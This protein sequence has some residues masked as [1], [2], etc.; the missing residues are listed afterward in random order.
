MDV[1]HGV[2]EHMPGASSAE[3]GRDVDAVGSSTGSVY[4]HQATSRFQVLACRHQF[5]Q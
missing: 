5:L 3:P 4:E 1:S 2:K